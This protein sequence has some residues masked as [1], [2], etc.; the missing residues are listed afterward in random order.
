MQMPAD[1]Q[2]TAATRDNFPLTAFA[3]LI[4]RFI[5]SPRFCLICYKETEFS[6]LKP[7]VCSSDLW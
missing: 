5:M 2:A 7:F 3:Y 6:C 1:P 4:R